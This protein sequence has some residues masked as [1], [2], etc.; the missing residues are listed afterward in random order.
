MGAL[1]SAP[2]IISSTTP[3]TLA[4]GTVIW[5]SGST[6]NSSNGLMF[7][8]TNFQLGVCNTYSNNSNYRRLSL[9]STSSF[10]IVAADSLGTGGAN[11]S[12]VLR[13]SGTG[14]IQTQV[15]DNTATGGN[16]RGANAVD[17][18]MTRQS[19]NQVASGL[20]SLVLGTRNEAS[21]L[22]S[23]AI[24]ISNIAS[25]NYSIAIG[26]VNTASNAYA[27]A[28]GWG[29][30]VS[31]YGGVGI[32]SF[33]RVSGDYAFVGGYSNFVSGQNATAFGSRNTTLGTN[34]FAIG[35]SGN[36][37][38]TDSIFAISVKNGVST[39]GTSYILTMTVETANATP[40]R[41][42]SNMSGG[43]A[44]GN[45]PVRANSA[46]TFYGLVTATTTAGTDCSSW[47]FK[48]LIKRGVNASTTML[49][50][51]VT[52]T[53]ITQTAGATTWQV[54]VTGDNTNG[55][56]AV[57]VTGEASK[58]IRWTCVVYAAEAYF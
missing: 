50:A 31:G 39:V 15:T 56:L 42:S 40:L 18:Q 26:A 8:S 51:S 22:S 46:T 4:A 10:A 55:L 36:I 35:E 58:T 47:E 3:T 14:A 41:V 48:G 34:S 11:Y 37:Q 6:V 27:L 57:T 49:V 19:A 2:T 43:W 1:L 5:T 21:A 30:I 17:L 9:T 52:P 28:M 29:N 33:H 53:L 45:Y 23:T 44:N 54:A 32:G 38:N 12:L 16:A 24:G 13:T 20:N 7:D 25:N